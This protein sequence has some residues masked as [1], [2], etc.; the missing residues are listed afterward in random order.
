MRVFALEILGAEG[1]GVALARV[2]LVGV[3]S[4][5]I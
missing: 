3:E 4:A 2:A 5:N 1:Q